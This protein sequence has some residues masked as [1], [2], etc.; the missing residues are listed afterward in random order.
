M[1]GKWVSRKNIQYFAI[2]WV[3]INIDK[4][5]LCPRPGMRRAREN[6]EVVREFSLQAGHIAE[7][8]QA[9]R[10][11]VVKKLWKEESRFEFLSQS[12]GRFAES[13]LS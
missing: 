6:D 4:Y 11:A 8:Q 13:K 10:K 1:G 9:A 5:V 3:E 12:I 2:I 7:Q